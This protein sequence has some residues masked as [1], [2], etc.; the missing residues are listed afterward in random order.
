MKDD[1]AASGVDL[2]DARHL[3]RPL[4]EPT[5]VE[6]SEESSGLSQADGSKTPEAVTFSSWP[7]WVN[8]SPERPDGYAGWTPPSTAETFTMP[9]HACKRAGMNSE[10]AAFGG[11]IWI[12]A[13]VGQARGPEDTS[14]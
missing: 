11:V 14:L 12:T 1:R 5:E 3:Q 2:D 7:G 4:P 10:A 6:L 8:R 9:R 13:D